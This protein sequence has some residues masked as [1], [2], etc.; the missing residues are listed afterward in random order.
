MRITKISVKKLFGVFDHEIPLNQDSRITILHGPNGVGKTVLLRMVHGLCRSDF[1]IFRDIPFERFCINV[2]NGSGMIVEKPR[3]PRQMRLP[4]SGNRSRYSE[5]IQPDTSIEVSRL[6]AQGSLSETYRPAVDQG[7]MRIFLDLVQSI[8]ELERIGRDTWRNSYTG[9]VLTQE[10]VI[11][12]YH[13]REE[14]EEY[15]MEEL[16]YKEQIVFHTLL[17]EAQRL[18]TLPDIGRYSGR[19]AADYSLATLNSSVEQCSQKIALRMRNVISEFGQKSSQIDRTFPARL[20]DSGS[21]VKLDQEVLLDKLNELAR[22]SAELMELGLLEQIDSQ[23]LSNLEMI[24][25]DKSKV[26]SIYVTDT[27]DKLA[28][29]DPLARQMSTLSGLVNERFQYK[30]LRF[31]E[32]EGFVFLSREGDRIPLSSLSSG[33]QQMLVLFCQLLFDVEPNSLVLIDEPEISLHV[34]WQEQFLADIQ[35]ASK[36]GNYDILIATHS[37]DIIGDKHDWMVGLGEGEPA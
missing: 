7:N 8:P 14:I 30:S 27:A 4:V 36:L 3:A 17:I 22:M 29:F 26:L 31:N 2:S 23:G 24:Q 16:L 1:A 33:E 11:D 13:M 18:D 35:R 37:P 10:E 19:F 12:D 5:W 32:H 21:A 15:E 34:N 20:M 9:S 6:D 25:E 28:V